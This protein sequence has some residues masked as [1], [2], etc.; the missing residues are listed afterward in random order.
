MA[1]YGT[2]QSKWQGNN[3]TEGDFIII[4]ATEG[5]GY[6]DPTCDAKYQMNKAAGKLLGVYD[7]ARPD[8]GSAEAEAQFF[9]D[10]IKG[11][12]GEAI[13]VL[14]WEQPGTQSNVGWAKAWLDK[15]YKL[16]GVRPLIYMSASVV[17]SYDWSSVAKD[18]GLWIAG[19]PNAYNVPNPPRPNPGDM[20]YGIGAWEF[21]AIWQYTSSAGTLDRD[22][23]NMDKKA[24]KKYAAVN[25]KPEPTPTPTPD[26][27]LDKYTDEQL[28]DMVMAGKFGNGDE[29][30]Q[31]LGKRYDAVQAIVDSRYAK[32]TP[33][34][35][36]DEVIAGK[37]G[38]GDERKRNL[39]AAGYNYQEVQDIVNKKMGQSTY[40][41]YCVRRGDTLSAIAA[42]YGT[43]VNKIMKDNPQIQNADLIY[44]GQRIIIKK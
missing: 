13:L 12:I 40:I 4:K 26:D 36:A 38:N 3:V 41:N 42:Q 6:V 23:A 5:V 37:W 1:L 20:P 25:G 35:I 43:T 7:F 15:V 39:E 28:A 22:I 2:D 34:Q 33:E 21:W 29:R 24:W 9:V 30:K 27:P 18:Y 16:T 17:N 14:D 19:Y 10:N 31:K 32:K 44:P 8:L 11:Y